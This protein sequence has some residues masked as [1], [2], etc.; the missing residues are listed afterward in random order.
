MRERQLCLAVRVLLQELSSDVVER[1]RPPI[2]RENE[3]LDFRKR[4]KVL[5]IAFIEV[6][7]L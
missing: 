7:R 6:R 5:K 1:W 2:L 4:G 3:P